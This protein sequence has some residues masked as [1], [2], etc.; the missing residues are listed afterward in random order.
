MTE[1]RAEE[2]KPQED[3]NETPTRE[4][5]RL[6]REHTS[7]IRGLCRYLLGSRDAAEDAVS[8][9]YVKARQAQA[10]YDPRQSFAAWIMSVARHYC[11]DLLRRR[12]IEARLF[13]ADEIDADTLP[14]KAAHGHTPLARIV[15]RESRQAV[16]AAIEKLPRRY[17]LPLVLRYYEEL[18][19]DDIARELGV[20]RQEVATLL[21]RAK[22]KLRAALAPAAPTEVA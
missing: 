17:R 13:T 14:D 6:F 21:F 1:A 5:D 11:F 3:R 15:D 16:Q 19:Y 2:V 20:T 22:Q 12:R 9:V 7:K 18:A 8:E 4:L 10:L